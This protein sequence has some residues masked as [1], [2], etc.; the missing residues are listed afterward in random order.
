M[1]E[2]DF[3]RLNVI[4]TILIGFG[5]IYIRRNIK[6]IV[7]KTLIIMI[8]LILSIFTDWGASGILVIMIFDYYY[9]N[10]NN[11]L[12]GYFLWVICFNFVLNY[13][14]GP[15]ENWIVFRNSFDFKF[16]LSYLSDFFLLIPII[17]LFQYNGERGRDLKYSKYF[18]YF[19]YPLHLFLI[20]LVGMVLNSWK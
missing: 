13:F 10:K 14:I 1:H 15:F 17:L 16:E 2:M 3:M 11:Q 7:L 6:N 20:G 18:F 12:F 4:F 19:F 8:L 9:G 5:A